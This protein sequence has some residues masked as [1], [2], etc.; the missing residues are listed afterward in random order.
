MPVVPPGGPQGAVPGLAS[1]GAVVPSPPDCTDNSRYWSSGEDH[2]CSG[3]GRN[4]HHSQ[5]S[6]SGDQRHG[7]HGH[8]RSCTGSRSGR[9]STAKYTSGASTRPRCWARRGSWSSTWTYSSS[10]TRGSRRSNDNCWTR[11]NHATHCCLSSSKSLGRSTGSSNWN[12][13]CG[14]VSAESFFS[15]FDHRRNG[16]RL[17]KSSIYA[18]E[19]LPSLPFV[20]QRV[21]RAAD[22]CLSC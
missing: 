19:L 8:V 17:E 13:N 22:S 9:R 16:L 21:G 4:Q 7:S 11:G 12:T 18:G 20:S 6:H 2:G 14:P 15:S 5:G 10:E 1:S 3:S